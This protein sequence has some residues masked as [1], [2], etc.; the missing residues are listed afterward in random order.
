MSRRKSAVSVRLGIADVRS[1][2]A[3]A[4]RLGVRDSDVFRYAVKSS[5]EQLSPL[6]D[7]TVQ[8]RHLLPVFIEAGS[9]L[10]QYFDLDAARLVEI[11]NHGVEDTELRVASEDLTLLSMAGVQQS[12]ALVKLGELLDQTPQIPPDKD[13]L[14][15]VLREY[16][17]EK[18]LY[19][20][21]RRL[22]VG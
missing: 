22:A 5:L 6:A 12:Y 20:S 15:D 9:K 1:L 13:G 7:P 11:V 21:G 3:I 8:G 4:K 14:V 2:K 10:L 19:R 17:Y 18:Y 16:L